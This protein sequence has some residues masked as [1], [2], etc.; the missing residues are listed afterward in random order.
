M[1]ELFVFQALC[2]TKVDIPTLTGE[3]VTINLENEVIKPTTVKRLPGKG[4]PF[5]KETSKRGDLLVTFNIIFPDRLTSSAKE[6][7]RSSLPNK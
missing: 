4:L 6:A 3:K 5:P 2:G 7:M 1:H